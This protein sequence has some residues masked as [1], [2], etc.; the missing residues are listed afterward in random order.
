MFTGTW[1]LITDGSVN[2]G[3]FGLPN[4]TMVCVVGPF[5]GMLI[6][7]GSF[8]TFDYPCFILAAPI[9]PVFHTAGGSS[10]NINEFWAQDQVTDWGGVSASDTR[11]WLGQSTS[12]HSV[13][14]A[15]NTPGFHNNDFTAMPT[16]GC[17]VFTGGLQGI[18][19]WAGRVGAATF[20]D[21]FAPPPP[22]IQERNDTLELQAQE[23]PNLPDVSIFQK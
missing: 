1:D 10:G 15:L 20:V 22:G 16:P 4:L 13:N 3:A 2:A 21:P 9:A 23:V 11:Y 18:W 8:E 12:V 19:G 6:D 17:N 7:T 14:P 5:G